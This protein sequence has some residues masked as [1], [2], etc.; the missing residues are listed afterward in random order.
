[1]SEHDRVIVI[2]GSR[3]GIGR[4]L[5]ETFARRGW[6]TYG[7]SRQPSDLDD[8]HYTHACL[9]VADEPAV[10]QLFRTVRARHGRLDALVNN[11]GIASMNLAMTTPVATLERVLRT[12]VVGTFLFSR[13]AVKLMR[14]QRHGRIVNFS[15]IAVP[16]KL[17]GES[18][19]VASKAAVE[20]MTSVLAKEYAAYG[21]TVN[22]IG[23]P[24]IDTDL[25]RG[26]PPQNLA[27]RV[28][29]RLAFPRFGELAEITH[30]VD[31]FLSERAGMMTGQTLYYGGV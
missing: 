5:A 14:R 11:A 3:K 25:V 23:P 12:N 27:E 2:T 1:M 20:A 7:C 10:T 22:T 16:L 31:F 6:H 26:I 29:D 15:T 8:E 28:L 19:Y 13:E 30:A 17:E 21:V 4:H 24:P 18:A 9:D